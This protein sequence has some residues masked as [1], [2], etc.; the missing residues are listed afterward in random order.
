MFLNVNDAEFYVESKGA[1]R[2][3]VFIHGNMHDTRTWRDQVDVL[4]LGYHCITYDIRGTGRSSRL[5]GVPFNHVSDLEGIFN[6]QG[7]TEAY[8][9]GLSLGGLIATNFT[10]EHQHRVRGVV[11]VSSDMVGGWVQEDYV[12]YIASLKLAMR[13][14]GPEKALQRY[15]AGAV[16]KVPMSKPRVAARIREMVS[17]YKWEVFQ[18]DAPNGIKRAISRLELKD[19][20]VPSLVVYGDH[21]IEQFQRNSKILAGEI[22]DAGLVGIKDCGHFPNLES[23]DI[24]NIQLIQFFDSLG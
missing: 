15:L 23:S 16:M 17:E 8:L 21:D 22:P 1:G 24:F 10:H 3:I 5:P 2:T 19:I 13:T 11:L 7:L 6:S 14:G 12:R 4:S 20:R 18:P 9:V